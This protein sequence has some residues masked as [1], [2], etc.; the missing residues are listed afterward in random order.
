MLSETEG[1]SP[2]APIVNVYP[3]VVGMVAPVTTNPGGQGDVTDFDPAAELALALGLG[4][5]VFPRALLPRPQVY[6]SGV[7]KELKSGQLR[8]VLRKHGSGQ[9]P[10]AWRIRSAI[11]CRTGQEARRIVGARSSPAGRSFQAVPGGRSE[12]T[13]QRARECQGRPGTSRED[14]C[15]WPMRRMRT[16]RIGVH[17]CAMLRLDR[18]VA[19]LAATGAQDCVAYVDYPA[20]RVRPL[21]LNRVVG[22]PAGGYAS[23]RP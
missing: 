22:Q 17:H 9:S 13:R 5:T 3:G 12:G 18:R 10:T 4:A 14:E 8:E 19:D 16:V 6:G 11:R 20:H 21:G 1:E 2:L 23:C 7:E 15:G